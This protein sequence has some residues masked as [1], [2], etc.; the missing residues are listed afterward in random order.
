MG[1]NAKENKMS[2][3]ITT[4][5]QGSINWYKICPPSWKARAY[6]DLKNMLERVWGEPA[7]AAK[8]GIEFEK[9]LYRAIELSASRD[10]SGSKKFQE[11]VNRYKDKDLE[12]QKKI[13]RFITLDDIEYCLYGK[14]DIYGKRDA[15][16]DNF[17]EDIKTTSKLMDNYSSKYLKNFQHHLYCYITEVPVFKYFVVVFNNKQIHSTQEIEYKVTSFENE[18]K[19]IED[20]I[21]KIFAFFSY[22]PELEQLYD[23][24]YCLY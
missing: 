19:I 4:S 21:K 7:E 15:Y 10:C 13:K 17:I 11:I 2:R 23:E 6:K 18:R 24:K 9:Y 20:E 3:L 14:L 5:L 1:I 22:N 16:T 12:I 8:L